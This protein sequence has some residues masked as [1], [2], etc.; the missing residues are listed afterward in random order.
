MLPSSLQSTRLL[1][2][3]APAYL[4]SLLEN[5]LRGSVLSWFVEVWHD[6]ANSTNASKHNMFLSGAFLWLHINLGYDFLSSSFPLETLSCTEADC[7]FVRL[8]FLSQNLHADKAMFPSAQS[9]HEQEH[10][11]DWD[12]SEPP[13]ACF[14]RALERNVC[15][16]GRGQ[17]SAKTSD[18]VVLEGEAEPSWNGSQPP[19]AWQPI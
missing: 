7:E 18:P 17:P 5:K 15:I 9:Q 10:H 13:G 12:P 11:K 2:F 1:T 14:G 16:I 3:L 4:A 19:G 8:I 6:Q